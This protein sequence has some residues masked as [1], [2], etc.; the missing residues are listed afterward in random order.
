[1]AAAAR[2]DASVAAVDVDDRRL[3]PA[4]RAVA[5]AE[6]PRPTTGCEGLPGDGLG[7]GMLPEPFWAVGEVAALAGRVVYVGHAEAPVSCDAA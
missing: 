7:V 6:P 1:M 4:R 3:E 5:H 2:R